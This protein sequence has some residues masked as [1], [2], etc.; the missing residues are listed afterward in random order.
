MSDRLSLL[1]EK[2]LRE[3]I[4]LSHLLSECESLD[5]LILMTLK[6][7][8]E[9]FKAPLNNYYYPCPRR[10]GL[11]LNR[12]LARSLPVEYFEKFRDHFRTLDPFYR[13]TFYLPCPTIVTNDQ[14]WSDSSF[15]RSE[16]YNDFLKPQSIHYQ[17]T[18]YLQ[19]KE[20]F[21]GALSFFRPKSAARFTE[22]EITLGRV[23][24]RSLVQSIE[25]NMIME[26]AQSWETI[27]D[28]LNGYVFN[29][30]LLIL[31]DY[32]EV[33]YKNKMV[34]ERYVRAELG[35]G[36]G[37]IDTDELLNEIHKKI[38]DRSGNSLNLSALD[39]LPEKD[40]VE[41]PSAPGRISFH[42]QRLSTREGKTFLLIRP[43]H[44]FRSPDLTDLRS[45]FNLSPREIEVVS[46]LVKG[47]KNH[48]IA[49]KLFI[50][51]F[52]V[53]NHL[54]SIFRKMKVRNRAEVINAVL[55]GPG[56]ALAGP[57]PDVLN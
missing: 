52:T 30:I 34:A 45:R 3:V 15:L 32:L 56:R 12:F 18:I 55:T 7:T 35:T 43:D 25:K 8:E 19:N 31:N 4:E 47:L 16:Y 54:R 5:E 24:G 21:L 2:E 22:S 48:E 27:L 46:Q 44:D 40:E 50:S 28:T 57:P 36:E 38:L 23:I 41:L 29:H 11:N 53:E 1:T 37:K 17:M 20:K 9:Y 51:L 6:H 39:P 10:K 49:Q 26:E 14:L 33:V 42:A 13:G